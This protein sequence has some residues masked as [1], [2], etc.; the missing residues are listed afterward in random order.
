[1]SDEN[2]EESDKH[3]EP[4]QRK[5]DEARRKGDVARSSDL[6][7]AAAYGGF[8]LVAVFFGG[9]SLSQLG[10]L[11]S[12]IVGHTDLLAQSVFSGTASSSLGGVVQS[13]FVAVLPWFLVPALFVVGSIVT[14][15]SLVVTPSKL[16]PK[17]SRISPVSNAIQKFG[18]RGLFEFS[19]SFLKLFVYAAIL[20]YIL[21]T[22]LN[23]IVQTIAVEPS[24]TLLLLF[25]L[26]IAVMLAVFMIACILGAIDFMWQ[27]QDHIRK[28]RMS[29]KDM[30]DE[31]KESE[32]DPHIKQERRRRAIELSGN[33]MMQDVPTA[34][35]VIVNPTHY[36][37]ALK[38]SRNPGEAPVCV[39]KGRDA[40][41]QRIRDLA[42]ENS[43]LV[44]RDPPTAR[45][46]YSTTEIGHEISHQHY[47]AVAVAIRF[48][49]QMRRK[50][51]SSRK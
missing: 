49:E 12:W 18:R 29:H 42:E 9:S 7:T 6:S 28:N 25:E 27:K 19:K 16:V 13:I 30:R 22:R 4:T 2:E 44:H 41:A 39:A 40:V 31:L 48:A 1:M 10:S 14:Q 15:R 21:Q 8:L 35:V 36:A 17:L 3:F 50:R 43:V 45:A 46:L 51:G 34:D 5:L 47:R 11:L 32:G 33:R 26:F 23:E 37:V 20:L 38:W 24:Q